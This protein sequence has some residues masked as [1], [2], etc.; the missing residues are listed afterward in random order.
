MLKDR[1]FGY[2]LVCVVVV[3]GAVLSTRAE[4]E[5]D[6]TVGPTARLSGQMVITDAMGTPV[7]SNLFH[8][9][10]IFNVNRGESA[11][12]TAEFAFDNVIG[13]VTGP[14]FSTIDG[15]LVS[16]IPGA[17]LWLI[18]PNGVVFGQDAS[19]D[20]QGSLYLATA[21]Y[22]VLEDGGRF[23]ADELWSKVVYESLRGGVS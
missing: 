21:D 4:I 3:V 11:T 14:G 8:S 2:G 22:I 10:S 17:D 16:R 13:R 20:L 7:G 6:G 15:P 1:N 5:F 12:F 9:F 23:A 18:N 19:L